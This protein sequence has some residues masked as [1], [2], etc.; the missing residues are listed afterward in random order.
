MP[1]QLSP[2][3]LEL[4]AKI[5]Q[6]LREYADVAGPVI[7]YTDEVLTAEDMAEQ[8]HAKNAVLAEWVVC[9]SWVDMDSGNYFSTKG[10]QQG[11]PTHHQYGLL[12]NWVKELL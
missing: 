12:M 4:N 10:S 9:M 5:E 11:M 8:E 2:R 6:L 1:E 7:E 3:Q